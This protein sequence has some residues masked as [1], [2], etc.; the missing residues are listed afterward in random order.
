MEGEDQQLGARGNNYCL[1]MPDEFDMWID[2]IP[3]KIED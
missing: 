1:V 2:L 3:L